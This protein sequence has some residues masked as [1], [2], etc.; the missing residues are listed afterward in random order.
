MGNNKEQLLKD[1]ELIK[2]KNEKLIQNTNNEKEK[3]EYKIL[4]DKYKQE[5][6]NKEN[7][8]EKLR[9]LL[10]KKENKIQVYEEDIRKLP[11]IVKKF[12]LKGLF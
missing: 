2:L 6:K 3:E 8:T 11:K 10:E 4:V 1:L 5:I 9:E 7:E 12:W